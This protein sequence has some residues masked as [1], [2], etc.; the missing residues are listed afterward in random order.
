MSARELCVTSH[1]LW[2]SAFFRSHRRE[3][4]KHL[5][6]L[7]PMTVRALYLRAVVFFDRQ[8]DIKLFVTRLTMIF[9]ARHNPLLPG[10]VLTSPKLCPLWAVH[11]RAGMYPLVCG[12]KDAFLLMSKEQ[13]VYQSVRIA[14]LW[15]E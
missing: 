12:R 13:N 5:L 9:V 6:H 10:R 14:A 3:G 4:G 1:T 2:G 8:D 7:F 15:R 11:M